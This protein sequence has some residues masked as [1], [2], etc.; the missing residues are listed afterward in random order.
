[1][2]G[3]EVLLPRT[4][5][6]APL[7]L[8]APTTVPFVTSFRDALRAA[9][10]HVR[11]HVGFTAKRQKRHFDRRVKPIPFTVGQQVSLY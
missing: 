8:D 9:H 6:A 4:L 11:H 7:E 3:R 10:A 5:I 2:L 1:M